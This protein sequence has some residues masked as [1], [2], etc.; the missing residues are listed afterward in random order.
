V[1]QFPHLG[2]PYC[3]CLLSDKS[4]LSVHFSVCPR[5]APALG[6]EGQNDRSGVTPAAPSC[7]GQSRPGGDRE[8]AGPGSGSASARCVTL[9]QSRP[10]LGRGGE[11]RPW[12]EAEV[13]LQ[14]TVLRT[15]LRGPA[16][17]AK[18]EFWGHR[19]PWGLTQPCGDQGF[20]HAGRCHR[21][22]T[23]F[24]GVSFPFLAALG[25]ELGLALTRWLLPTQAASSASRH[26]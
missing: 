26:R 6:T 19:T 23:W 25:F 5:S 8:P 15:T 13:H 3:C 1:P 4:G 21:G 18:W 10:S 24:P 16:T 7:Q 12:A 2:N 17:P 20:A 14:V 22:T 9:G 11:R